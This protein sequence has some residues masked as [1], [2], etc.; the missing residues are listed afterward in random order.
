LKNAVLAK[1]VMPEKL[2]ARKT[3]TN[4]ADLPAADAPVW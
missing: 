2:G 4:R 3:L 1:N